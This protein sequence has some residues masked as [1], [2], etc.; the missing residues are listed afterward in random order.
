MGLE[1][2]KNTGGSLDC[3]T[4]FHLQELRENHCVSTT[5]PP[6]PLQ[7]RPDFNHMIYGHHS[8]VMLCFASTQLLLNCFAVPDFFCK[9]YNFEKL[10]CTCVMNVYE[11]NVN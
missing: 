6:P 11:I 3:Y 9:S 5:P 8:E 1:Y 4:G 10:L 2:I 7:P